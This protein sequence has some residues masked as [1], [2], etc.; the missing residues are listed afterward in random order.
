[1]IKRW[2]HTCVFMT[3]TWR[4][5]LCVLNSYHKSSTTIR[6]LS[7]LKNLLVS[8]S[9]WRQFI[10]VVHICIDILC[11]IDANNMRSKSLLQC[12]G[13]QNWD[14]N[15]LWLWVLPKYSELP[16]R[17]LSQNIN[18]NS[19]N[20]PNAQAHVWIVQFLL[21]IQRQSLGSKGT[22]SVVLCNTNKQH[23]EYQRQKWAE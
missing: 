13:R 11:V 6:T 17:S 1:M 5:C 7:F 9:R 18:V 16:E 12:T 22:N 15:K 20:W 2:D 21:C 14:F 3:A 8:I 19:V 10:Y 23:Q 4:N